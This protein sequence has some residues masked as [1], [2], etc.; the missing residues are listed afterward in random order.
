MHG[1]QV[2]KTGLAAA[3]YASDTGSRLTPLGE[4]K[5]TPSPTTGKGEDGHMSS[6][7]RRSCGSGSAANL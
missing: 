1:L 3:G 2:P 4:W 5:G 7:K 6:Y